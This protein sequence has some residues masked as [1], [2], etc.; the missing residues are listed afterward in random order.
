MKQPSEE[1][2]REKRGIMKEEIE[3]I[4]GKGENIGR[5]GR[6][7]ERGIKLKRKNKF[8]KGI[9]NDNILYDRLNFIL[10]GRRRLEALNEILRI[11]KIRRRRRRRQKMFR[12]KR[13]RQIDKLIRKIRR[14]KRNERNGI[15]FPIREEREFLLWSDVRIGRREHIWRKHS[16]EKLERR[17]IYGKQKKKHRRI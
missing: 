2:G 11:D 4:E 8:E 5:D 1:I 16:K 15:Q 12:E 13:G 17:E 6:R 7:N 14:I 9:M 3:R 10:I